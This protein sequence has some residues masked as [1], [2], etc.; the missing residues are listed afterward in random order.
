MFEGIKAYEPIVSGMINACHAPVNILYGSIERIKGKA[1]GQL[2]V[3]L[4]ADEKAAKL[5]LDYLSASNV[6]VKGVENNVDG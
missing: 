4:P 1:Y 2:V 3:E 6:V 5:A